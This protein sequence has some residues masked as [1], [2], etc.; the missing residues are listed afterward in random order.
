MNN[1]SADFDIETWNTSSIDF[2]LIANKKC[3]HTNKH[4]T[5]A[6]FYLFSIETHIFK[7]TS[8]N[9]TMKL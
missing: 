6:D 4:Y 3:G 2:I 9:F 1:L 7:K 5:F 8:L